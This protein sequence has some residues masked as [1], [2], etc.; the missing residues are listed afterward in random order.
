MAGADQYR[1]SSSKRVNLTY[2][3]V[4]ESSMTP[5][6]IPSYMYISIGTTVIELRVFNKKKK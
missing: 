6:Q 5:V 2:K 4:D 3:F 1:H